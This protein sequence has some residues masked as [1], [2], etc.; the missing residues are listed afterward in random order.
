MGEIHNL[1]I[2]APGEGKEV[3]IKWSLHC[4]DA[5]GNKDHKR[6]DAAPQG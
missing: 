4:R 3:I 2:A 1:I 6:Q 5:D